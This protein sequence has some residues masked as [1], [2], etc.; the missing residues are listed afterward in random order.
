MKP[1]LDPEKFYNFCG[2]VREKFY[3]I[4]PW[5]TM[6]PA[7][8]KVS[9][10][11]GLL[12]HFSRPLCKEPGNC[13]FNIMQLTVFLDLVI[14]GLHFKSTKRKLIRNYTTLLTFF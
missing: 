7:L 14:F 13:D 2:E 4:A 10:V 12:I 1:T 3:A 11:V 8:H 5:V 9:I 6:W